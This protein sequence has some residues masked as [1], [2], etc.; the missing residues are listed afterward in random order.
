M[1]TIEQKQIVWLENPYGW[2]YWR[3]EISSCS[4][5]TGPIALSLKSS[6]LMAYEDIKNS[7]KRSIYDRRFWYLRAYDDGMPKAHKVYGKS[8]KIPSE[9]IN[10]KSISSILP[11]EKLTIC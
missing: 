4:K 1:K 10:P 8:G 2:K 7:T 6:K 5:P 3:E 11:S 9:G